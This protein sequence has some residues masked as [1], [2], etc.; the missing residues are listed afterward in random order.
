MSKHEVTFD[1]YDRYLKA[2]GGGRSDE[3]HDHGW[4]RGRRPVIHIIR[5]DARAYAAWL[6][7]A[8]AIA[9]L[10]AAISRLRRR[11]CG[12][13][14]VDRKCHNG[15]GCAFGALSGHA[16]LPLLITMFSTSGGCFGAP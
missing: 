15:I 9:S 6:S 2:K 3:A 5:T 16:S 14:L 7:A 11:P 4:G 12:G 8:G 10:P 1:D 13:S